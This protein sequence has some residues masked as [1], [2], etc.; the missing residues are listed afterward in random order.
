MLVHD[1]EGARLAR[2]LQFKESELKAWNL[3]IQE[4]EGGKQPIALCE[5]AMLP[6]T[7]LALPEVYRGRR[8]VWYVDNTSATAAFVKGASANES[9]ECIVAIFWLA[10]FHLDCAIWL[11]WVD[12]ESN[13]SDGLSRDLGADKF[14]ERHG[15]ATEEL[16]ADLAWWYQ[17]LKE[18]WARIAR[19]CCEQALGSCRARG[20]GAG[21][22]SDGGQRLSAASPAPAFQ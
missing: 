14:V 21:V 13:W 8:I 9:L 18:V 16:K 19:L 11:E 1:P 6:L 20:P 12:S 10:C 4:I 15:F 17:P 22:G 5:A 7:L 3:S 2:Y